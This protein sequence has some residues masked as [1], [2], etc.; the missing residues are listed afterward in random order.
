MVFET[1][2]GR[3]WALLCAGKFDDCYKEA[4]NIGCRVEG[5]VNNGLLLYNP[6]EDRWATITQEFVDVPPGSNPGISSWYFFEY[7]KRPNKDDPGRHM[8]EFS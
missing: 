6:R 8:L 5:H 2:I 7:I 3:E 4:L 1:R